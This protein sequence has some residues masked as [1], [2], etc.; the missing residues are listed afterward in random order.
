MA[1]A[2]FLLSLLAATAAADPPRLTIPKLDRAPDLEDFIGMEGGDAPNGMAR[3]EGFVQRLPNDGQP[4][5]ERTVVYIGYDADY[6]YVLFECFDREPQRIGAHLVGRDL[7]PNDDDTVSVH[8]DTF[9]DLKHAYGF[10]MNAAG[11]QTD[12]TYTEGSG[13][14]LSWDAVW[15]SDARRTTRGTAARP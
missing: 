1:P 4:V 12:G 3:V 15:R 8:L 13:W 10:Q 5:S 6:V 11:V 7:L 14:D 9:R 2:F